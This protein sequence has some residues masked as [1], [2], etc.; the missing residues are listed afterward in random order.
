MSE[1]M[2]NAENQ[3]ND[4]INNEIISND[5]NI[6]DIV[7]D[8]NTL[9]DTVNEVSNVQ[10]KDE[11]EIGT[12]E[13]LS[14]DQSEVKENAVNEQSAASSET[15]ATPDA[16]DNSAISDD[17]KEKKERARIARKAKTEDILN[18]LQE[19]KNNNEQIEVDVVSRIKGGLIVTYKGIE[20]FLPSSHF[21]IQRS[22]SEDQLQDSIGNKLTVDIHDITT[23]K[24]GRR[25]IIVSRKNLLTKTFFESIKLG[26]VVK[27]KITSITGFGV[28]VDVDG[29]EGL[30][31]ISRLSN[32][33]IEDIN[34]KFKLGDEVEAKIIEI[35]KSKNRLGLNRRAL[36]P[37]PWDNN[38]IQS[39]FQEGE[40]YKATIKNIADFGFYVELIPGID[41]FVRSTELSWTKRIKNP[42]DLFAV[43]EEI[44]LYLMNINIDKRSINLSYK[45]TLSNPWNVFPEKYPIGTELTGTVSQIV[46]AG[47]VLSCDEFD[48]FMPQSKMRL[49]GNVHFEL[50][51]KVQVK[52]CDLVPDSETIILEPANQ[53]E[54]PARPERQSNDDN[55][56]QRP[57]RDNN[58]R[59]DRPRRDSREPR[60]YSDDRGDRPQRR[61]RYSNSPSVDL[62]VAEPIFLMDLL[63]EENKA[64]LLNNQSK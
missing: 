41:G 38:D 11:A 2:T 16:I 1:E 49:A 15:A 35:N 33:R 21:S 12:P 34:T 60:S 62:P 37:S 39:K 63:S 22:P 8:D 27:G 31:H 64:K 61:D 17:Q 29:M 5:N 20:L 10:P 53:V 56:E 25:T 54:R 46:P 4:V 23:N 50:G 47:M 3:K 32:E 51:D 43:G 40:T 24:N 45:R 18:E 36:E 52:I 28:F 44:N 9:N 14:S 19:K 55:R 30:I 13:Q 6:N 42:A 59:S 26:Q 7:A 48:A 57:R 58:E